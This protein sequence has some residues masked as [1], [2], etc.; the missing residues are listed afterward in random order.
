MKAAVAQVKLYTEIDANLIFCDL[1]YGCP[2][3]P[4]KYLEYLI[5]YFTHHH[6]F[7]IESIT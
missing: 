4:L 7:I 5:I 3:I 2:Y 6:L 1:R